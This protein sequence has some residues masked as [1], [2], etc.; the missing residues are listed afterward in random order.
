MLSLALLLTVIS[1]SSCNK[2]LDIKPVGSVM[3]QTA[4]DFRALLTNTYNAFPSHRGLL[5]LRT[6]ELILNEY[7]EDVVYYRDIFTWKDGSADPGTTEFPYQVF[8]KN[9][10]NTNEIIANA[11]GKA[12]KNA[13][14]DQIRGEAYLLRAY[15]H[16]ELLNLYA[17]PYNK[18]TAST[19][20][21]VPVST[22]VDLEKVFVPASVENVYT[23]IFSDIELAEGLIN[24]TNYEAGKNYRFT[25]RA[26][27][28]FK[29]R[30]YE[31]RGE[32]DKALAASEK[33]LAFD[34]KLLDLNTENNK[35]VPNDYRSPESILSLENTL[36]A[37][38][39]KAAYV[40][41]QLIARYRPNADLR[42]TTFFSKSGSRY[43]SVKTGADN[44]R[45]SFRNAEM[46]LI[47]SEA[48]YRTGN[49]DLARQ[50][51]LALKVKRF[52]PAGYAEESSRL[53][54]LNGNALLTEILDERTRELAL[55][56]HRWYDLRRLGQPSI[57][58]QYDGNTFTLQQGDP[59]YTLRFP[60]SAIKNN[61]NLR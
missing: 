20:R 2:Y 15:S 4:A 60:V 40:S 44:F 43:N 5:A 26:L 50:T 27:E 31:Y 37:L 51:L 46:Y 24:V 16:F 18:E 13:E 25:K 57:T 29:A 55:E 8:Y 30:V 14:T 38:V 3:P 36:A 1:V 33:A 19:E 21:G 22:E 58:H 47:K 34:D 53:A 10:F 9:I 23:Q 17:R 61:P 48:A 12:G 45:V 35:M 59:K 56:G 41:P 52:T 49:P 32:W 54:G 11:A 7:S 42:L 28:A 6:D 39:A